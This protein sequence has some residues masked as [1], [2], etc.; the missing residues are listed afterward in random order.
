VT[1]PCFGDPAYTYS[2]VERAVVARLRKSDIVTILRSQVSVRMRRRDPA[3]L[4]E[5]KARYE[6]ISEAAGAGE[7][8]T[9][10]LPLF[11]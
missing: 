5:L 10:T 1:W 8:L 6:P 3:V 11:D 9:T 4:A 2:D 7:P